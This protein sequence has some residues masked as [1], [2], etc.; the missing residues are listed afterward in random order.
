MISGFVHRVC[1]YREVFVAFRAFFTTCKANYP[2]W[3]S[4]TVISNISKI[5][6]IF[7]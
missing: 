1:W 4:D 5:M 2:L 7:S 6:N 3:D